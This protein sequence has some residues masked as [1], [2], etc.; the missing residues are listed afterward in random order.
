MPDRLFAGTETPESVCRSELIWK[1]YRIA[2]PVDRFGQ[3]D[4]ERRET[5][6]KEPLAGSSEFQ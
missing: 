2:S 5:R 3:R 6:L 1:I 4:G